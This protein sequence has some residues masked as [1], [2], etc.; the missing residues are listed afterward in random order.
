MSH[1]THGTMLALDSQ[2]SEM[3]GG[4]SAALATSVPILRLNEVAYVY[5]TGLRA[6]DSIELEVSSGEVVG[7][8]GPS[9]CGK[10]TLLSII[11]GLLKPTGGSI[12]W[13]AHTADALDARRRLSLVFQRDTLLPWLTVEKN[14]GFG[15]R[16]LPI[17]RRERADRI[18]RLLRLAGLEDVRR[19]YPYQLSGGMRRRVAFLTG[20]APLPRVL[21]LDEPFSALDE[22]TRVTIHAE[23]L[24]IIKE[25]GMT[26]L[27]VTH[28]LAEAISF[29]D[30][31]C[32]LTA[33]PGRIAAVHEIPFGFPRDVLAVRETLEYQTLY[34]ALWHQLSAEIAKPRDARGDSA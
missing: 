4:I 2:L 25:L 10:S 15:L 24:S 9:G 20:V 34:R 31:A 30:R 32:I 18:S 19:A 22:P 33:R 28:D 7:I 12:E 23:V 26:V 17:S 21:L 13:E 27:L 11:A 8:V 5:P 3:S 14:V 6:L 29:S 1:R 16:Y